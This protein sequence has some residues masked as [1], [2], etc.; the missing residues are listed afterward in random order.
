MSVQVCTQLKKKIKKVYDLNINKNEEKSA[1]ITI[2]IGLCQ[3]MYYTYVRMFMCMWYQVIICNVVTERN[4]Q[5][6]K[7]ICLVQSKRTT[8]T[9]T[10]KKRTCMQPKKVCNTCRFADLHACLGIVHGHMFIFTHFI[11]Y[12]LLTH[13]FFLM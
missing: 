13:F 2:A 7:T 6:L 10:R 4:D 8:H 1:Y 11:C 3:C 12:F 9:Y 5:I